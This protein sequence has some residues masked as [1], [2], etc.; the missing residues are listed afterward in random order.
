[1]FSDEAFS[2]SSEGEQGRQTGTLQ[3]DTQTRMENLKDR[4]S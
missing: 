4:V 1:M 3:T 2:D